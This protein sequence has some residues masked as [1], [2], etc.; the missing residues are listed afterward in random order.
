MKNQNDPEE[1]RM[2]T[3]IL[4]VHGGGEGAFVEDAKLVESLRTQLGDVCDVIYPQMPNE[5]S[6]N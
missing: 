4:F 3:S 1:R 6:P 2:S 5:N